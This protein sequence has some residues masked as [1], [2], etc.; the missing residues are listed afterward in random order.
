MEEGFCRIIGLDVPVELRLR[1]FDLH[2][3]CIGGNPYLAVK[4]RLRG[5][6]VARAIL[7]D[8]YKHDSPP[9][10]RI[11]VRSLPPGKLGQHRTARSFASRIELSSNKSWPISIRP[12][13]AKPIA[14]KWIRRSRWKLPHG[15]LAARSTGGS[16][17]AVSGSEE[18]AAQTADNGGSRL[19][20]FVRPRIEA[21]WPNGRFRRPATRSE[22]A[23]TDGVL[24]A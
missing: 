2:T 8:H 11:G 24:P 4:P 15:Q 12:S 13:T 18:Y 14:G 20:I 3:V 19:L 5:H 16:E 10:M 9:S 22:Y 17:S 7:Q 23:R 6:L 1:N 21:P